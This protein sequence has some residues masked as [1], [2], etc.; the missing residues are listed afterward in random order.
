MRI[1][2]LVLFVITTSISSFSQMREQASFPLEPFDKIE[3]SNGLNVT[4]SEET[5]EKIDVTIENGLTSDVVF[6][7]KGRTLSLKLKN[8]IGKGVIVNVTIS[9]KEL[10]SIDASMGSTVD[11]EGVLYSDMLDLSATT[12]SRI[13]L[14]IDTRSVISNVSIGRIEL[15]GETEYQEINSKA[16]GKYLSEELMSKQALVK[17]SSGGTARVFVTEKIDAKASMGGTIYYSGNP[18]DT[19]WEE[20]LGGTVKSN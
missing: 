6:V 14:K 7:V 11:N 9:Y 15:A 12:D 17:A 4:L 20:T 18:K 3:I 16:G 8:R 5:Q 10:K 19:L 1:L 13:K 2:S